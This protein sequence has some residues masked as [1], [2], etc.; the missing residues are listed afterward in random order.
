MELEILGYIG[1]LLMGFTLGLLGGGGSILAVPI[2]VFLFRINPE[3]ATAYSLFIV[4]T[5]ALVGALRNIRLKQINFKVAAVFALPSFLAV[6][7]TRYYVI[8]VIPDELMKI[9]QF[10]LTKDAAIMLFFGVV[11]VMAAWAMIRQR[12]PGQEEQDAEYEREISLNYFWI[13]IEGFGI[14]F[15]TG[16]IGAGGGFLIVPALV[17]F[18][19]LEM[20]VAVGT[21]LLIIAAKSLLG[22]LG[23]VGAGQPIEWAF[24]VSIV[25]VAVVGIFIGT[26]LSRRIDGKKLKRPFG[27]FVLAMAVLIIL[28]EILGI[29]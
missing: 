21:S 1:I 11:M 6:F 24:L 12:K 27:W 7:I 16:L 13:M 5:A 28:M 4:G 2:L 22:W 29:R 3:L 14:G 10:I 26:F 15:V 17:L 8:P 23:D 25:A 20:K 9:G 19:G 18:V